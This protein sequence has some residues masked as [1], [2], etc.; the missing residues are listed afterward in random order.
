MFTKTYDE[1]KFGDIPPIDKNGIPTT[2]LSFLILDLM[3][4]ERNRWFTAKDLA[5]LLAAKQSDTDSICRQ[6]KLLDFL[7]E[8]SSQ[9][10]RYQYKLNSTNVDIQSGFEKFLVDVRLEN[11]PVHLMLDYSPSLRRRST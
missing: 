5:K 7:S 1:E 6:L 8:D 9:P 10:T 11:L 4:S 2:Y 3:F